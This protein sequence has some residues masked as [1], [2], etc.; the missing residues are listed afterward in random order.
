MNKLRILLISEYFPPEIGAGSNRAYELSA[1]WVKLGASVSVITGFPDYPSGIIPARYR[2]KIFLREEK[3]GIEV[4]RTFTIPAPNKGFLKR[5][6]SFLSFMFSSVIQGSI[7]SK[8]QDI[9][10]ATS[11]PFF[12]GIAGYLIARLKKVPF[13]FEV[14][15]LWPDSIVELGQLRNRLIIKILKSMEYF[16]Y[17]KS[18]HIVPVADSTVEVLTSSGINKDKI[19]VIKN[20]VDTGLFVPGKK[21]KDLD[22]KLNLKNKFVVGYIGTLGLSHSID[23]VIGTANLLRENKEISFLIIGEGAE[24]ESLLQ[25]V[26]S[27]N[28]DNVVFLNNVDKYLLPVYYGLCDLL[29]VPLRKLKLFEKVIPSK[30]FEIF[31]M[32]KPIIISVNG[33]ARRLVEDS[34]GGM[35]SEPENSLELKD[36]ILYLYNNPELLGKLGAE[37]R[38]FVEENFDRTVLAKKYYE[39]LKSILNTK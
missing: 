23:K 31:A 8:K 2:G 33:E 18:S 4:I 15:D 13:I 25:K 38:K 30:I 17:R 7:A 9:V 5:V 26:N 16:L 27:L 39:L 11:P 12:V 24:K 37:G 19:T 6:I 29:L 28:L 21:N 34:G 10:I 3:D 35:Y 36:K 22:S 1:N 20:G 32:G 14:R